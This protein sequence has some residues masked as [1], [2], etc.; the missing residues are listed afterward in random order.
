M[1]DGSDS[2]SKQ[3]PIPY[4]QD[5]RKTRN[6]WPSVS[7]VSVSQYLHLTSSDSGIFCQRK[8]KVLYGF[9]KTHQATKAVLF[10]LP[11]SLF[12]IP[13]VAKK[14]VS[15]QVS[16]LW[17]GDVERSKIANLYGTLRLGASLEVD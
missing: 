15:S 17:S 13:G 4:E 7:R 6:W 9:H 8:D 1:E 12:K 11:F 16:L 5:A 14:L 2:I 3:H 10:N